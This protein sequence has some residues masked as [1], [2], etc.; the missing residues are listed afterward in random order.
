MLQQCSGAVRWLESCR[1][2]DDGKH[3]APPETGVEITQSLWHEMKELD[4]YLDVLWK[5]V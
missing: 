4:Y 2:K 5:C 3:A 1:E